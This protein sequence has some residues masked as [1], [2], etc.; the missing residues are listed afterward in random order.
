[1]SSL[2]TKALQLLTGDE[3]NTDWL[4]MP[5]KRVLKQLTE[6]ELIRLE[7]EI[8]ATLFGALPKGHR[9]EF[10]C[11]DASTW[12][13]HEEWVDESTRK[14]QTATT[15]YEVQ[16]TGVLKVQEGA[17][18]SYVDGQELDNLTLAIRMYYER[19]TRE[20]YHQEPKQIA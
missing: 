17:R 15:R 9:R 11:L 3:T 8:G 18:Y 6:R 1:M 7:A 14:L 16:P 4:K 5:K 10:F 13:W 2:I 19:V 20:I 12:I